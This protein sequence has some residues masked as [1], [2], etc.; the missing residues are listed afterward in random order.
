MSLLPSSHIST[1][2]ST[3]PPLLLYGTNEDFWLLL[4]LTV[5]V[6]FILFCIN[7]LIFMLPLFKNV[8]L[9]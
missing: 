7:F 2:N 1:F 4:S 6:V 9:D 5:N 3:N 8:Q